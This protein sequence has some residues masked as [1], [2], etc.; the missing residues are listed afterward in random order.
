M[1][2]LAALFLLLAAASAFGQTVKTLGYNTTNGQVVYSGTNT[3]TF[4]N[5][6]GFSTNSVATTRTNLGLGDWAT[7]S[8]G[9]S[10]RAQNLNISDGE[11]LDY[12]VF[13]SGEGVQFYGNRASQFRTALG[14]GYSALTNNN[15]GNFRSAISAAPAPIF[16]VLTNDFSITNQTNMTVVDGLTISTE[17]GRHYVVRLLPLISSENQSEVQIVVS[18]ATVY[19]KWTGLF[20]SGLAGVASTTNSMTNAQAT[21]IRDKRAISQNFYVAAGT[22][23]GSI[24]FQF[25]SAFATNTNTIHAGS[26]MMAQEV[27]PTP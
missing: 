2:H 11:Q 14:L 9:S 15:A 10:L 23:A 24:S 8:D 20:S 21:P 16:K 4:T 7:K 6:I 26:F 1:K 12:I 18:N 22:N 19:G 17:A 3:L 27:T 5:A 25:R 13:T